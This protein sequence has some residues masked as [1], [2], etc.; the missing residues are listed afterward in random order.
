MVLGFVA[1]KAFDSRLIYE[2]WETDSH[3]LVMPDDTRFDLAVLGSSH[4]N[5]LS[6]FQRNH[7]I[8]EQELGLTVF[9]MASPAG[10]GLLQARFYFEYFLERGN[11]TEKLIYFLDPFVFFGNKDDGHKFVYYEPLELKFLWKLAANHYSPHSIFDYVRSKY[12]YDWFTQKTEHMKH[13][14]ATREGW[15]LEPEVIEARMDSLYMS[16]REG[17][18]FDYF[19]SQLQKIMDLCKTRNIEVYVVIPPTMI[20]PEP[21]AARMLAWLETQR[22]AY[23]FKLEVLTDEMKQHRFFYDWDHLNTAGVEHL[24]VSHL[25]P[26]LK[27]KTATAVTQQ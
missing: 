10:G 7:E 12:S 3:L 23:D 21:G 13:Y 5:V 24:V 14:L 1:L 6:R 18:H 9:N 8:M 25:R 15:V 17:A 22:E 19:G 27:D 11:Q 16:G 20:G 4:A 2:P 26:I